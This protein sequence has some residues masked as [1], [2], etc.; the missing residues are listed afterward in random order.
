MA[1]V[2]RRTTT[3]A[4]IIFVAL[5][6]IGVLSAVTIQGS[7]DSNLN[8]ERSKLTA[9]AQVTAELMSQQVSG[10][11]DIAQATLQ[12]P[13][14]VAA[15][16][17]PAGAHLN[18][19]AVQPI[20]DQVQALRPDFRFAAVA[21]AQGTT[22]A[23]APADAAVIGQNFAF[24]DWYSG[25][26][27]TGRAYVS[28]AYASAVSGAPL[29]V[30]IAAP[31]RD[32]GPASTGAVRGVLFIGYSLGSVQ[33]FVDRLSTLQQI[34]LQVTDQAGVV[35][36][37]RGGI[38]P[39]LISAADTSLVASA[40][41]G[42]SATSTTDVAIAAAV[43]ISSLG[44]TVSAGT[45]L[46][47]TIAAAQRANSW[48]ISGILLGVLALAGACL[49][50]ATARVER[51]RAR[52]AASE[53]ELRT[54]HQALTDAVQ[55][56][57]PAGSLV[58]CNP[59]AA[60]LYE[61]TDDECTTD[62]ITARW[63]LLREDGTPL[64]VEDGPLATAMRAGATSEGVVVGLRRRTTGSVRWLSVSTAPIRD[65]NEEVAGYVSAARDITERIRT[66]REL[67]IL[68]DAAEKMSASLVPDR[69]MRALTSAAAALCSAP[70]EPQR[71]AQVFVLEGDTMVIAG[72]HD[73]DGDVP[74]EGARVPVADHPYIQTVVTTRQPVTA[75]IDP[76]K[77]GPA[78]ARLVRNHDLTTCVWIPLLRE[79]RV[80]AVLSIAG[81]QHTQV[82]S[83]RLDRLRTLASIG[84][85][86]L[87]N[88]EAHER[89]AELARTD[90]LTGVGN[91]R[92]LEER[93]AQLPRTRFA[94]VA[95]DVD[96]LK[97]VNDTHGHAAG[98]ELLKGVAAACA[99]Q[100]RPSDA[101]ARTGGD[102]FVA[103][104][105]DSDGTGAMEVGKRMQAAASRVQFSWGVASI[106]VG[107]AAGVPGQSPVT[108]ARAAD[109]ALYAAK[110]RSKRAAATV[111]AGARSD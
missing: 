52:Q 19:S 21:D 7:Y 88:A 22:R 16:A 110:E 86:A 67:G 102:E 37:R 85:L 35:I 103:L 61:L 29:V 45:P 70:G 4:A 94:V 49:V 42:R 65:T 1:S 13:D 25:V 95:I 58:S 84:Q 17:P 48:S 83:A 31:I 75:E 3:V 101:L 89:A 97:R 76:S 15:V 57:G 91:R 80:F 105:V 51:T 33:A 82:D 28:T 44:W 6:A 43:P 36:A 87:S 34:D 60:R 41:A 69:V 73:V 26:I 98:D 74:S 39:H 32:G 104:L 38:S 9:T 71:R 68:G 11:E 50:F 55:F 90:P 99:A 56:Y 27:R 78:V 40:L 106:S 62:A 30:A 24:R 14:F 77:F 18:A 79:E 111:I 64:P 5:A 100:L 66:I 23:T 12:R 54:V 47:A 72:E 92:A 108:V 93:F 59:A 63:E 46:S 53:A 109:Q 8:I 10:I 20:L 2:S 107:S 81:R 96:D